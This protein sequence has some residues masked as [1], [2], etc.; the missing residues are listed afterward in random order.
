MGVK[1]AFF[2]S[3]DG[4]PI[5]VDVTAFAAVFFVPALAARLILALPTDT[6]HYL[7]C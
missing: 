6:F 7:L 3:S 1:I 5:T 2:T 4:F